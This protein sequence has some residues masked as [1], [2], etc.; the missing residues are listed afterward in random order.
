MITGYSWE[1]YNVEEDPT[2]AN[3]LAKTMPDKLKLIQDLFYAEAKKYQVLPLDDSTL[4]RWNTPRPCVTAG[5]S[6]LLTPASSAACRTALR[7]A[8]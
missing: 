4:A 3:D 5:L 7:R 2:E 8:S 1:L 6:T